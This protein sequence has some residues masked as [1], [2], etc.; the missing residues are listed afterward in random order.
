MAVALVLA[1]VIVGEL[2]NEAPVEGSN[3]VMQRIYWRTSFSYLQSDI[4]HSV[5]KRVQILEIIFEHL[6]GISL[7]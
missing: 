4:E 6:G 2:F 3:S 7:R 5:L 1:L